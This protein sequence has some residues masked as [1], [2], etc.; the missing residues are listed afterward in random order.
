MMKHPC[1]RQGKNRFKC[2]TCEAETPLAKK[3]CFFY[4]PRKI[5][6]REEQVCD[7]GRTYHN[8]M[9]FIKHRIRCDT[10]LLT[11]LSKLVVHEDMTPVGI[12]CHKLINDNNL[13]GDQK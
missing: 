7:C 3:R 12:D 8:W 13:T 11:N 5:P 4:D 9:S 2:D 6:P 10:V 1:Y